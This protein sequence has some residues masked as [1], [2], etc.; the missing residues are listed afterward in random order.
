VTTKD[1]SKKDTEE[2]DAVDDIIDFATAK[3]EADSPASDSDAPA[4]G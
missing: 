4:P 2:K 3:G 1:P